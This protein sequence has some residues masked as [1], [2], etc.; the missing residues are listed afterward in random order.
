MTFELYVFWACE[1]GKENILW[2]LG[3]LLTRQTYEQRSTR[4][5][6]L[7]VQIKGINDE[8][9]R[10]SWVR[11]D[12]CWMSRNSLPAA[13]L[14]TPSKPFGHR[15]LIWVDLLTKQADERQ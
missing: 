15:L 13:D 1:A 10:Q 2:N 8:L 11:L 7:E 14:S 3:I 6:E 4:V 9:V 5:L 12:S